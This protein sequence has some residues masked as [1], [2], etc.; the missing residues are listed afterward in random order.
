MV[1]NGVESIRKNWDSRM[2]YGQCR[3]SKLSKKAS[4]CNSIEGLVNIKEAE[5]CN[6]KVKT[7][8]FCLDE[9]STQA[10]LTYKSI[11]DISTRDKVFSVIKRSIVN[12][13][14]PFTNKQLGYRGVTNGMVEDLIE[15]VTTGKIAPKPKPAI[16]LTQQEIELLDSMRICVMSKCKSEDERDKFLALYKKIRGI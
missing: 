1:K 8:D 6:R 9:M 3:R 7:E 14:D 5:E 11:K 13:I 12:D 15:L 10:I 2:Q 16:K 4:G